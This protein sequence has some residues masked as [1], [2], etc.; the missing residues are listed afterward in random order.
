MGRLHQVASNPEEIIDRAMDREKT[1]DVAW[2]F[3]APHL[4]LALSSRLV[5]DFSAVVGVVRGAVMNGGEGGPLGRAVAT[6]LIRDQPVG[7]VPES[8]Q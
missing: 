3:E 7:H 4:A 1:L 2:G 8:L 6:Q 5:R